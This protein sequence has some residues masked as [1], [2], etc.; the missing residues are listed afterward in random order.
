MVAVEGTAEPSTCSRSCSSS[1]NTADCTT[2]SG[3]SG[4]T[5]NRELRPK[6]VS[7]TAKW[8]ME[9][10]GTGAGRDSSPNKPHSH[11]LP[12]AVV[13]ALQIHGERHQ[14]ENRKCR[15]VGA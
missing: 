10:T 7:I 12:S 13:I 8:A 3:E 14:G 4:L 15:G 11:T 9:V 6:A 1:S 2:M 5:M